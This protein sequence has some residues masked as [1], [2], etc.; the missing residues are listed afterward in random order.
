VRKKL[1]VGAAALVVAGLSTRWIQ[2]RAQPQARVEASVVDDRVLARAVVEAAGGVAKVRARIDGRVKRVLVRF[3]DRVRAGDLLAEIEE[4]SLS[5]EVSRREAERRA[6][7]LSAEAIAEGARPEEREVTAAS[8]AAAE[9]EVALAEDRASR[10]AKLA[11][12]GG[13]SE[14]ALVETKEALEIARARLAS[15]RAQMAL[16]R[17]GGRGSEARAAQARTAAA[18]AALQLAKVDLARTRLVSPIDGVILER[19]IDPGD[20]ITGTATGG[21]LLPL[22]EV[23]DPG[24]LEVR[25]EVEDRDATRLQI[26]QPVVIT[27]EGGG[28]VLARS[29]LLR[30]AP[31]MSSRAISLAGARVRADGRIRAAWA[32]VDGSA[33]VIGQQLEAIVI[34][35][36]HQVD[37]SVPK[38]AV[39]IRDGRPVVDVMWGPLAHEVP[40]E[41]GRADDH[42]VQVS[43]VQPGQVVLLH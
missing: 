29:R 3:G 6:A 28:A 22:F 25:I 31:Q 36:R 21:P 10:Q 7:E 33:L 41:V 20:T 5:T 40:V 19:R 1:V 15:L 38:N 2:L 16:A 11:A 4:D 9:R 12:S 26:D 34:L 13:T 18:A 24:R 23:A 32:P 42:A 17:A 30:L 35:E 27:P 14:S 37:A 8:V 43:G 39:Q